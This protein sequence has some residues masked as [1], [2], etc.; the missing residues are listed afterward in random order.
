MLSEVFRISTPEIGRI[1]PEVRQ[2]RNFVTLLCC[3]EKNLNPNQTQVCESLYSEL[4]GEFVRCPM[5]SEE[6]LAKAKEFETDWQHPRTVGAIDGKHIE[7]R[8]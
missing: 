3:G 1:I 5:T 6:W 8:V 7:I 2:S 4:K